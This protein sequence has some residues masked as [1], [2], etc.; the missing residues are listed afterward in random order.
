MPV[1]TVVKKKASKTCMGCNG[2]V[3]ADVSKCPNC[4]SSEMKKSLLII[5][6]AESVPDSPGTEAPEIQESD[7][8]DA[9]EQDEEGTEEDDDTD[10]DEEED[11]DDSEDEED[12]DEDDEDE[13]A[14]DVPQIKKSQLPTIANETVLLVL[15]AADAII[16]AASESNIAKMDE[17]VTLLTNA[18]DAALE[19]WGKGET[20]TKAMDP[21]MRSKLQAKLKSLKAQAAAMQDGSDDDEDDDMSKAVSKKKRVI[22]KSERF[23]LPPEIEKRLAKADELVEK[24]AVDKYEALAKSLGKTGD[25]IVSVGKTLRFLEESNPDAFKVV[26]E[27]F[28]AAHEIEKSSSIFTTFGGVGAGATG[29][30]EAEVIAKNLQEKDSNLT[31]EQALAKAYAENPALYDDAIKA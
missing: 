4:G 25:E 15:T 13:E 17:E 3:A 24:A 30:S 10:S 20:I 9:V 1:A 29:S 8:E 16:K 28:A 7:L 21:A 14:D 27:Q 18:F 23:E 31:K 26:K 6:K 22:R 2:N 11:D 19:T 5:R 12:D